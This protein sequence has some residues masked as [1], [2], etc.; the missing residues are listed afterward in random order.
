MTT[1]KWPCSLRV[2]KKKI[3]SRY[4]NK[5]RNICANVIYLQNELTAKLIMLHLRITK[6]SH[7]RPLKNNGMTNQL[8]G[9]GLKY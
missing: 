2:K 1:L 8:I 6:L 5:Y 3:E 7:V 9:S 4:T